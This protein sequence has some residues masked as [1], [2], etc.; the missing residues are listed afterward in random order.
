[1]V[2]ELRQSGDVVGIRGCEGLDEEGRRTCVG[3]EPDDR[4]TSLGSR[5]RAT[6]GE[7]VKPRM[8]YME[9]SSD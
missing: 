2:S 6:S 7:R 8:V 9:E 5:S 1:M 4:G 3:P